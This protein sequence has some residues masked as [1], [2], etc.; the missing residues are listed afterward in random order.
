MDSQASGRSMSST[1]IDEIEAAQLNATSNV[2]L[3]ALGALAAV[4]SPVVI[5]SV[6]PNATMA[7]IGIAG[8]CAVIQVVALASTI[9]LKQCIASLRSDGPASIQLA[10]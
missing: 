3:L 9:K 6:M 5:G 10:D 7:V 4:A 8:V 1:A 2:R